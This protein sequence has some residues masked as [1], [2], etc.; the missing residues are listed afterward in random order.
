MV[1]IPDRRLA[2]P[3]HTLNRSTSFSLHH[4][5]VGF[6]Q[7][8]VLL[9][10]VAAGGALFAQAQ[11]DSNQKPFQLN[12]DQ[13]IRPISVDRASFF[14]FTQ[15]REG[16]IAAGERGLIAQIDI[17][18]TRAPAAEAGT[19]AWVTSRLP[20]NRNLT[21]IAS[22][23]E[24]LVVAVGHSGVIFVST[25]YGK[26]WQPV[27]NEIIESVNPNKDAL[28]SV[29]IDANRRILV[30]GAFGLMATSSDLGKSWQRV[31]PLGDGFD[32]HI[33]GLVNDPLSGSLWMVGESGTLAESANGLAWREQRSPYQGSFFG[34]V[35]TKM[36]ARI[37]FGMRGQIFRQSQRGGA[38]V[39][40]TV[41]TTV[42]WMSGRVLA[43]GRVVLLG[44][45]G[46]VAVSN[47]DGRSFTV[48]KI[49]TGSLTDL[50]ETP[51]GDL[52]VSGVFGIRQFNSR[53]EPVNKS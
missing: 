32:W 35:V 10:G 22:H 14:A 39:S 5:L 33:Y 45:Q 13:L 51:R 2:A 36:G 24:G 41:P 17:A 3:G 43:D 47:D 29:T 21:A 42:A 19:S 25:D 52:Y 48:K 16:I 18:S 9:F 34:G 30:A 12:T 49:W 23:T 20:T 8:V 31:R 37:A 7:A 6:C 44:D 1:R 40:L 28:L 38:W 53:L 46:H 11:S 27:S 26:N 50:I 4:R 15:T